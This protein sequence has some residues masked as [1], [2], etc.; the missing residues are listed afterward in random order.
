M[1]DI[2]GNQSVMPYSTEDEGDM[3]GGSHESDNLRDPT[4]AELFQA[5]DRDHPL[6]PGHKE[7][8]RMVLPVSVDEYCE[9]FQ[10]GPGSIETYYRDIGCWNLEVSVPW[11]SD[12]KDPGLQNGFYA[13]KVIEM[14]Q[15]KFT[16]EEKNN[17]FIKSTD[18]IKSYLVDHRDRYSMSQR[19]WIQC[20]NVPYADHFNPEDSIVIV[21]LPKQPVDPSQPYQSD[22]PSLKCAYR[23]AGQII[24]IKKVPLF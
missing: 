11:T 10:S 16:Q 3:S 19:V 12:V 7:F 2:A 13:R 9:L 21:S 15:I 23:H 17:A 22:V 5:L 4:D 18:Q 14:K 1:S 8:G 6:P 24:F 20:K